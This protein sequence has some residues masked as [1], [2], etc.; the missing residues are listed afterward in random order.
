MADAF[1]PAK[2]SAGATLSNGNLTVTTTPA[3]YSSA[4]TVLGRTTGKL[5]AEFTIN[6]GGGS[7]AISF[8]LA[9]AS[10]N[11]ASIAGVDANSV[12]YSRF[13]FQF[14][15]NNSSSSID[16]GTWTTGSRFDI[17]VD[18][19]LKDVWI[20][21]PNGSWNGV[22]AN[23]SAGT[24]GL[25]ATTYATLGNLFAA[26]LYLMGSVYNTSQGTLNVGASAFAGSVPSGFVAWDAT[27]MQATQVSAE[28]WFR[29]TPAMQAT[30]VSVE[31]WMSVQTTNPQMIVT[32]VMIEEWCSVALASTAQQARAIILA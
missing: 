9:N 3:A 32:Q 27:V 4:L 23:P 26:P 31:Q 22:G 12:G 10:A 11:L 16:L 5:Y 17:A 15:F 25:R 6:S 2:K 21:G 20:R 7:N 1:D 24:N 28:E 29:G 8:G 30:Q 19:A 13:D 14:R 18:F